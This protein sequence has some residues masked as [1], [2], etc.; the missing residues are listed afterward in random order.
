MTFIQVCPT[1]SPD[2]RLSNSPPNTST[3]SVSQSN[4]PLFLIPLVFLILINSDLE[5]TS[6]S[7]SNHERVEKMVVTWGGSNSNDSTFRFS[8][9]FCPRWQIWRTHF[10]TN[11]SCWRHQSH[12]FP[13]PHICQIT[14][15]QRA[16]HHPSEW[17]HYFHQLFHFCLVLRMCFSQNGSLFSHLMGI[18]GTRWKRLHRGGCC[19]GRTLPICWHR[20]CSCSLWR[21]RRRSP[22][23]TVRGQSQARLPRTRGSLDSFQAHFDFVYPF[24]HGCKKRYLNWCRLKHLS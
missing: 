7:Q 15:T 5:I 19:F 1:Y 2:C 22:E 16:L 4:A 12:H 21:R 11:H 14:V 24:S 9:Y 13:P 20:L 18:C 8:S 6:F 17:Y 10:P 23:S 3:K